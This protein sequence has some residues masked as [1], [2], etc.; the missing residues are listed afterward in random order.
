[1]KIEDIVG[2]KHISKKN[3]QLANTE[4]VKIR[5]RHGRIT[6]K[7]VVAWARP[8]KNPLHR[9]FTWDN[10]AA[11]AEHRLY[12]ASA[13]IRS[14]KLI[15]R[16]D[17]NTEPTTVR[18]HIS[19]VDPVGASYKPLVEVMSVKETR[20]QLLAEALRELDT[21]RRKYAM[22]SGLAVVFAAIEKVTSKRRRKAA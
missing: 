20:E 3:A 2:S 11:A 19:V 10:R 17:P 15:I 13:L 9:F 14:I 8:A 16:T 18:A 1:M 7:L 4:L 22:L 21:F 12:E 5:Q 6:P